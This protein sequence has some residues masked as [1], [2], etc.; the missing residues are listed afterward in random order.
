MN[1]FQ[2]PS[3]DP[4]LLL[5]AFASLALFAWLWHAATVSPVQ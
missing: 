1:K 2:Y 5:A 3:G 4:W